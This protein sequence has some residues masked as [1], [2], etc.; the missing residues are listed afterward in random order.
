MWQREG[1]VELLL[2]PKTIQTCTH[3]EKD[4]KQL[5]FSRPEWITQWREVKNGPLK[6]LNGIKYF[7]LKIKTS[8]CQGRTSGTVTVTENNSALKKHCQLW[9]CNGTRRLCFEI[10]FGNLNCTVCAEMRPDYRSSFSD[11][12]AHNSNEGTNVMNTKKCC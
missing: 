7:K 4:W 9:T 6:I 2:W 1:L 10:F 8:S 12:R 3:K 5:F 11:K